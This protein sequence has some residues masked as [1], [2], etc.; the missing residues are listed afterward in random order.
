MS[1]SN[2]QERKVK[3]K[4]T[5]FTKR[6]G[7]LLVLDNLNFTVMENEFLCIVGPT[8]CGKTTLCNLVTTL[9]E[10]T[11]GSIEINGEPADPAKHNI[12]FVFQEPSCLPWRTLWDDIKFGL[13][14][15]DNPIHP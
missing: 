11:S 1:S 12:S 13:E 5:N 4:F 15:K 7:D 3:I 10:P 9:I 14:I 8:G 6:F 2:G